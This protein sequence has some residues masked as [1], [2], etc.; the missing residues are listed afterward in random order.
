MVYLASV[1]PQQPLGT[2]SASDLD[3]SGCLFTQDNTN[4]GLAGKTWEQL[5]MD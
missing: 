1:A 5:L 2:L 3:L 4:S